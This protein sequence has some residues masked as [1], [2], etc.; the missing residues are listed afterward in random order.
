MSSSAAGKYSE[1]KARIPL[2]LSGPLDGGVVVVVVGGG[3]VVVVVVGAVVVGGGGSVVVVVVVGAVVVGGGGSVVVVVVGAV[4]V[5]G[6]GSVVVVS[7]I[8]LVDASSMVVVGER[9]VLP[10]RSIRA[11]VSSSMSK[12]PAT[13]TT[14]ASS[15]DFGAGGACS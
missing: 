12:N 1:A 6:G 8:V 2:S 10:R 5:G 13:S 9:R 14:L 7:A 4:V 3:S 11:N 15:P